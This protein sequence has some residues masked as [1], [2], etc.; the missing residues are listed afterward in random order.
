MAETV[1]YFDFLGFSAMS[2]GDGAAAV[3]VL[4]D[5]A[6]VLQ[7]KAI[8]QQVQRWR[9]R[10]ALSDSVF[11]THPDPVE[12]LKLGA[13][14]VQNLVLYRKADPILVRG[15]FSYGEVHHLHGIFL[16]QPDG[17][18]AGEAVVAA[19]RMEQTEH[20]KGPRIFIGDDL[21]RAIEQQ[22]RLLAQWLLRPTTLAGI[23]EVLWLL[24]T[25]PDQFGAVET[26]V[27]NLCTTATMMLQAHGGDATFGSHYR[28]FALLAGRSI[29]RLKQFAE[30]GM[31]KPPPV[32][33]FN[34][35]FSRR[36]I[37]KICNDTTGLPD[38]F[39][40]RIL[41]LARSMER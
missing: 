6:A 14:L 32:L 11:L 15:A 27:E 39:V 31:V 18:L 23:W 30:W 41:D 9:H 8:S 26:F 17:N 24:P 4:S 10:Y 2:L 40:A 25:H 5:L 7:S 38:D 29:E 20:L 3:D 22:D 1:F 35:F 34:Q 33:P 12:A 37:V 28:E 16:A 36:E 13:E 21:K 19:V